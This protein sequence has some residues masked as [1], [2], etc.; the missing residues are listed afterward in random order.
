[1]KSEHQDDFRLLTDCI[2]GKQEAWD[3]F[4]RCY[5]KLV[6]YSITKALRS[7][8]CNLQHEDVEDIYNGLFLSLIENDY[9]KL[10]QFE[11]K[12]GCTLSSWIRLITI[13]HTIDFLRSQRKHISL[14][15]EGD[16]TD[17]LIETV[18]DD[19]LP[20]EKQI[21]QSETERIF[22]EAISELP[23]SDRL[24]MK[25][26]YENELPP[27]EIAKIMHVSVNT[28]Y[29]KKNRIREKI[30]KLFDER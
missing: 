4:V 17:P 29:S 19:N 2:D 10:R 3:E 9:K 11:G 8:N 21:E 25:L 28:I 12:R 15:Q 6:Y 18:P 22:R 20:I 1:M 26:Y 23:S 16:S 7:H 24:F 27:E 30:K 5:S 14:D 13:R